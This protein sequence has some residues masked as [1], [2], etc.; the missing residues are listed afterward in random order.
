MWYDDPFVK[1]KKNKT[2]RRRKNGQRP[3]L[4]VHARV[5][6]QR[7]DRIQRIGAVITLCVALV[8]SAWAASFGAKLLG[9]QVFAENKA[10]TIRHIMAT[11]DADRVPTALIREWAREG[12][13]SA[14]VLEGDNLFAVD[15]MAVR[16]QILKQY[17]VRDATIQRILPDTLVIEVSERIPIARL[18]P[19]SKSY[20]FDIDREGYL[21]GRSS[22]SSAQLPRIVGIDPHVA[23]E[24]GKISSGMAKYAL[25]TLD[26]VDRTP[27][28]AR[29]VD[30]E[31]I[32]VGHPDYLQ[33]NL[34]T[35]EFVLLS[36][37]D[38]KMKLMK[39]ARILEDAAD[40]G[41]KFKDLD[42][43]VRKNYSAIPVQPEEQSQ[44]QPEEQ[45]EG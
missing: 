32:G 30:I 4:M 40:R 9:R 44:E 28:V 38:L 8:G 19:R 13:D 36:P 21:L 10:Y 39:L 15:I 3:I 7:R 16:K 23:R 2:N 14:P 1:F 17:V 42:L 35:G 41:E 20:T 25:R 24:N 37:P 18:G 34:H 33:M 43:T 11:S 26:L 27:G 5:A 29:L 22:L 31:S 45:P 6:E 12:E